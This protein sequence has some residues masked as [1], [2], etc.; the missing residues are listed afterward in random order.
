M[1][2]TSYLAR[3]IFKEHTDTGEATDF[4]TPFM[5]AGIISKLNDDHIFCAVNK[6]CQIIINYRF[7]SF[8]SCRRFP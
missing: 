4:G 8:G 7:T 2:S 5:F 1:A 3:A 6:I